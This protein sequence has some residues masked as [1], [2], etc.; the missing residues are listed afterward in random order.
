MFDDFFKARLG[1]SDH[2]LT[3][4]GGSSFCPRKPEDFHQTV[5][6]EGSILF[7][8]SSLV[9]CLHLGLLM[10]DSKD[11][12]CHSKYHGH[13]PRRIIPEAH[14]KETFDCFRYGMPDAFV[15]QDLKHVGDQLCW[16]Q[17]LFR[18][19]KLRS[20]ALG[21]TLSYVEKFAKMLHCSELATHVT[22]SHKFDRSGKQLNFQEKLGECLVTNSLQ[23]QG[24]IGYLETKAHDLS[25]A[26]V[27]LDNF[28]IGKVPGPHI[29]CF[30]GSLVSLQDALVHVDWLISRLRKELNDGSLWI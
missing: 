23:G 25:K 12:A 4:L 1:C 15:V 17:P 11:D 24:H 13:S 29:T 20:Y 10:A 22:W 19:D 7:V 5:C 2:I 14:I 26:I 3:V 9:F 16:A 6:F 30:N 28:T 18:D 21:M 27:W 8:S